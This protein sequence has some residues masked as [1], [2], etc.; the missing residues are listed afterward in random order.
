MAAFERIMPSFDDISGCV[1]A[2]YIVPSAAKPLVDYTEDDMP[3]LEQGELAQSL[4]L[5]DM[6]SP[7]PLEEV[8]DGGVDADDED[9][10]EEEA[11][12]EEEEEDEAD[13]SDDIEPLVEEHDLEKNPFEVYQKFN[14]CIFMWVLTSGVITGVLLA[15]LFV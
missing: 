11:E 4:P 9:E 2:D 10:A 3:A 14:T 5:R 15:R 12:E 8:D 7:P 13:T 1:S 6:Q